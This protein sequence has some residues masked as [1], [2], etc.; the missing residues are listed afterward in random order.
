MALQ[1]GKGQV[2]TERA[3]REKVYRHAKA[4][5]GE[6]EQSPA[7][8]GALWKDAIK[9]EVAK[10]LLLCLSGIARERLGV[11]PPGFTSSVRPS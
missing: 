11:L 6:S 8:L 10:H 9:G 2:L 5:H 3:V 4:H 7:S 1:L